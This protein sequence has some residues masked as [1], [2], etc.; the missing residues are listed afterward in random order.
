[1]KLPY[2]VPTD[3][4]PLS[5]GQ[6]VGADAVALNL[7]SDGV[8]IPSIEENSSYDISPAAEGTGIS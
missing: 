7:P 5:N 3:N 1:L 2:K 8:P 4:P 6:I